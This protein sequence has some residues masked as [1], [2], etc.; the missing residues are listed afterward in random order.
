MRQQFRLP[1]NVDRGG[2]HFSVVGKIG[3]KTGTTLFRSRFM[4]GQIA[5]KQPK[6]GLLGALERNCVVFLTEVFNTF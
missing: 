1:N 4:G 2:L 5:L 6:I 3:V